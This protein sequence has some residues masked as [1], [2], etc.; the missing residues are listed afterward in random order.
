MARTRG[1]ACAVDPRPRP[2][3]RPARFCPPIS[4][5]AHRLPRLTDR[6]RPKRNH[7]CLLP[8]SL[9][10]AQV[11]AKPFAPVPLPG[12]CCVGCA[13]AALPGRLTRPP[14]RPISH[15]TECRRASRLPA[16]LG[17]G[18]PRGPTDAR[19]SEGGLTTR[20]ASSLPWRHRPDNLSLPP[21]FPFLPV[22]PLAGL[23]VATGSGPPGRPAPSGSPISGW[24]SLHRRRCRPLRTTPFRRRTCRP[25]QEV[26]LLHQLGLC[27]AAPPHSAFMATELV[28][29]P[30]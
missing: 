6:Q 17:R 30:V 13:V 7:P 20:A 24:S 12:A 26:S 10:W 9:N 15:L 14:A 5:H 23:S 18:R 19:G 25:H 11:T 29:P 3:L 16:R 8:M 21:I 1:G 27:W 2:P 4:C 28:S 22:S